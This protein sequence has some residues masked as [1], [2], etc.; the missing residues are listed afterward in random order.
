ME[1]VDLDAFA[2]SVGDALQRVF[3][4]IQKIDFT[5]FFEKGM[6]GVENFLEKLRKHLLMFLIVSRTK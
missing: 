5:T 2:T 4:W 1:T 6:D 3:D